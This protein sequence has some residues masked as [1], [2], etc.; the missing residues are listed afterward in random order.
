MC[1]ILPNQGSPDPFCSCNTEHLKL[2]TAHRADLGAYCQGLCV[3]EPAFFKVAY[4][5]AALHK[6]VWPRRH[7]QP[8]G[9]DTF[10]KFHSYFL[11]AK[12]E[13]IGL[14]HPKRVPLPNSLLGTK[15]PS[16]GS[17]LHLEACLPHCFLKFLSG[18]ARMCQRLCFENETSRW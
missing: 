7:C 11:L 5:Q 14:L 2:L 3:T 12:H 16:S 4:F 9:K 18:E 6:D 13:S 15:G 17:E 8:G 1:L 10:G